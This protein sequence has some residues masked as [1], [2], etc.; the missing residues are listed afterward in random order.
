MTDR[1]KKLNKNEKKAERDAKKMQVKSARQ[2]EEIRIKLDGGR[3][4]E[5]EEEGGE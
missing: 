3:E 1:Q 2:G 4:I 5:N